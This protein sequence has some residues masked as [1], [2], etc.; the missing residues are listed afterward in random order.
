MKG[1]NEIATI[2]ITA[3][4]TLDL[5]RTREANV[6]M[7]VAKNVRVTNQNVFIS[8]IL[9]CNKAI[10]SSLSFVIGMTWVSFLNIPL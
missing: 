1:S 4:I 8:L 9:S 6:M 5:T 3:R 10:R 2:K 7:D